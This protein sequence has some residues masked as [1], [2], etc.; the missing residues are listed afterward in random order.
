MCTVQGKEIEIS[1]L[2]NDAHLHLRFERSDK[3][4]FISSI[5]QKWPDCFLNQGKAEAVRNH[6]E[7]SLDSDGLCPTLTIS[8]D[9]YSPDVPIGTV[10]KGIILD[11]HKPIREKVT[12]RTGC[13]GRCHQNCPL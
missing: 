5:R 2:R 11:F 3:D 1:S 6:I 4:T 8:A 7:K 12:D 13:R 10:G 9:I